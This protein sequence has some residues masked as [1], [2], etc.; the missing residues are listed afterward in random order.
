MLRE[1]RPAHVTVP[2]VIITNE[3][4]ASTGVPSGWDQN[5]LMLVVVTTCAQAMRDLAVRLRFFERVG[6]DASSHIEK[7]VALLVSFPRFQLADLFFEFAH[8]LQ[9][10]CMGF[11]GV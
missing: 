10:I 7:F 1:S 9:K 6:E 11:L 8:F 2:S 3:H 4:A 5:R